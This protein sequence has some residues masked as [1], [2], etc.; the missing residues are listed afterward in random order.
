M[1]TADLDR[2]VYVA[3]EH[4]LEKGELCMESIPLR[5]LPAKALRSLNDVKAFETGGILWGNVLSTEEGK[6][7]LIRQA[8]FVSGSTP[9]FNSNEIDLKRIL[10]ALNRPRI[11]LEPIGYFRSSVRGNYVP[12]EGDEAFLNRHMPG[13]DVFCLIIE[14]QKTGNCTAHFY[15]RQDGKTFSKQGLL[16]VPLLP[17]ESYEH[18][19][20]VAL[21]KGIAVSGNTKE[22]TRPTF[23]AQE[24]KAEQLQRTNQQSQL[25]E[26]ARA[27]RDAYPTSRY[28]M[29][30][31]GLAALIAVSIAVF[32]FLKSHKVDIVPNANTNK[33][34]FAMQVNRSPDGQLDL[35]WNRDLILR[36]NPIGAKLFIHDGASTR[37]LELSDEQLRSGRLAYFPVSDD[38]DFRLE[39]FLTEGRSVAESIRVLSPTAYAARR[40]VLD[41]LMTDTKDQIRI[42]PPSPAKK[43]SGQSSSLVKTQPSAAPGSTNPGSDSGNS[44]KVS[45]VVTPETLPSST[46]PSTSSADA[47]PVSAQHSPVS[48]FTEI[49][50]TSAP[51]IPLTAESFH[52]D[53]NQ[54]M[55]ATKAMPV[56]VPGPPEQPHSV[57]VA[58]EHK[59]L[60]AEQIQNGQGETTKISQQDAVAKS[61]PKLIGIPGDVLP[62]PIKQVMPNVKMFGSSVLVRDLQ[63]QVEVTLDS[64]GRVTKATPTGATKGS[65]LAAQAVAAAQQWRFEPARRNGVGVPSTYLI[66]FRFQRQTGTSQD[67]SNRLVNHSH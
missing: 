50:S 21:E 55:A 25:A 31:A 36:R 35:I 63:V 12:S 23:S 22:L 40:E 16:E 4:P 65:L 46:Q 32:S 34:E 30:A 51:V 41:A 8:E 1:A 2:S 24:R 11:E 6:L 60:T 18:E 61:K 52:S 42:L 45:S 29:W 59:V 64:M 33:G 10:A 19:S 20:I 3:W 27:L 17:L 49:D 56:D 39:L 7:V 67:E 54:V 26:K 44:A 14:P 38:T 15:F 57:P 37:E 58:P 47:K 28:S 43:E 9:L 66:R 62:S 5:A 13:A 53:T 48:T